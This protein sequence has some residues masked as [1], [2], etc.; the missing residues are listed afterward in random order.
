MGKSAWGMPINRG[1]KPPAFAIGQEVANVKIVEYL[2][3]IVPK[4]TGD[5]SC[6]KVHC[7]TVECLVCGE[8]QDIT[9]ANLRSRQ[10]QAKKWSADGILPALKGCKVCKGTKP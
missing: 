7:Y 2:G 5:C 6:R 4:F 3:C 9:Q 8:R 1:H 10:Y